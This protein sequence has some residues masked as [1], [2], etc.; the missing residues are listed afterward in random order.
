MKPSVQFEGATDDG[1]L[2]FA[3]YVRAATA[4]RSAG[5][6]QG[7]VVAVMLRNEPVFL[8]LMLA[9][10]W[11][12]ARWCP[13]NWHFKAAEVRHILVDSEAKMLVV[14]ADLLAQIAG[15]IPE[16]VQVFVVEPRPYTRRAYALPDRLP[17][18]APGAE[19]WN[20]FRDA[21]SGPDVA[22]QVPG[23][24]MIYTS[25]TTGLP[26][27]IRRQPPTPEQLAM[28]AERT[29][30]A[31]GIGPS[32]RA[33]MGA[34]LYHSAPAGYVVQSALADAHIVIE[35]RF[36][37]LRTLQL[38]EAERISHLYLVPTMY[39]RLLRLADEDRRRFDL[40][41]VRFVAS[42]GSPC[43]ADVKRQMIDWWGPVFHEAYAASELGWIS[44]IESHES[45]L[46]P[47]SAGRA[48]PG[49]QL[50]VLSAEGHEV[51]TGTVGLLHARDP[52]VPDF[53][54]ANNDD[55]RRQLERDGL[56]TSGDMGYLDA[57]GYLYVVDRKSDMVISGGANIYPAEI[58]AALIAMP[59]VADY[60]ARCLGLGDGLTW[61]AH[62]KVDR[63][64]GTLVACCPGSTRP[65][66][67][68]CSSWIPFARSDAPGPRHVEAPRAS[69][70]RS[71][72]DGFATASAVRQSRPC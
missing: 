41:S 64:S 37:A 56:W 34:P 7:E 20:R 12:G 28:L 11:I 38:I 67:P 15:A 39:V 40:S 23:S 45:M 31:L 52:A 70:R 49:V 62:P 46:R 18:L 42:T 29:R 4:L 72:V 48:I 54:Y 36:D 35:P 33:L 5:L 30:V 44:H 50:K 63:G 8:E 58:E 3:R 66:P 43:A 53:T 24:A 2:F 65:T 71:L 19:D 14:H 6:A 55:A 25:G 10:R 32:M 17:D 60:L 13:I 68:A 47:G 26:R 27:G 16:G 1:E 51:P 61:A 59:G 69:R 57:E 22:Q 9:A 21:T